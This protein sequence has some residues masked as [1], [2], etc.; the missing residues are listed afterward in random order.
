MALLLK[1]L[2]RSCPPLVWRHSG[3]LN[4]R[5][6]RKISRLEVTETETWRIKAAVQANPESRRQEVHL[7][8]SFCCGSCSVEV[9][10]LL[11]GGE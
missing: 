2:Q 4:K 5:K 3:L 11:C 9:I 1:A 8:I 10:S 6:E 7:S